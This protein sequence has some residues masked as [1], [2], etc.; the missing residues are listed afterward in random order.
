MDRITNQARARKWFRPLVELV[1]GRLLL[2]QAGALGPLGFLN[3][4]PGFH[5]VRPNTPV[6]PFGAALATATYIDP[7]ARIHNGYHVLVGQKTF[8]GPYAA[9]DATVGFIKIGTGSEVLDNAFITATPAGQIANPTS[10]LIGD[11]TSIGFGAT[12]TGPSTIGAYAK[13]AKATGIGPNAVI[14]GAVIT[15]GAIVGALAYVGP[16]VTVPTGLFVLPGSSVTTEAEA[17]DPALG[18]VEPIPKSVADDL[19]TELSRGAALA[20]G[21]AYLYQGQ[22]ATGPN[23]GLDPSVSGI[24]NGDLA[25]VL[26]TSQQ[27]G[28]SSATA[29]TGISFEPSKSGPKF[30]GRFQPMTEVDQSTFPARI[31]GD[32]R[33]NSR[34]KTVAKSLGKLNAFRADQGQP[35]EFRGAPSTGQ[36][37]VINSPLGGTKTTTTITGTLTT[38]TNG[39]T[40]TATL[41]NATTTMSSTTTGAVTIGSN[42]QAGDHVVLL[43]GPG[44]SFTVGNDV[45]VGAASVITRSN[46]GNNVTI[47]AKSYIATSTIPDNSVVPPGTI[48]IGNVVVGQ[49]QW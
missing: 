29:A 27:P 17:T 36:N 13:A 7:T 19:T 14:N 2:T 32:A 42:F 40:T 45:N 26:G 18:K 1:E 35:I 24:F 5:L 12:I 43:G 10:V 41:A 3:N 6:A 28:P 21:Y 47:G 9:L 23:A 44:K 22:S 37:V 46:L 30:T 11:M 15:P 34:I 33:F 31:T 38:T 48:M 8:I 25:A 16:G 49:V 20:N 39:N 4:P